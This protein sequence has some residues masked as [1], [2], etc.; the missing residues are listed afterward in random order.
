MAR[1]TFVKKAQQRFE[2]VAVIDPTTGKQKV[3]PVMGRDGKQ[4]SDKNGR[5]TFLRVTEVDRSK[6]LPNRKCEKCGKEIEVGTP[7]KWIKPKSGPY[8]GHMKVRCGGCP[9]WHV[10]D[11]SS[12]LSARIAQISYEAGEAFDNST[13]TTADDVT[14]ILSTAA[15]SI[16]E[17]AEEKRESANNIEEG[18]GHETEK[19]SELNEIADN[20]ESWADDVENND[21]EDA[22]E[23]N[24][25]VDHEFEATE[26]EDGDQDACQVDGCEKSEPEHEELYEEVLDTWRDDVRSSLDILE[27][28]P[29]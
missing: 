29:V 8:G 27:E 21:V 24:D 28:S 6:P 18:F 16:R 5:L 17:L 10:W 23:E 13:I 4:K 2:M 20:L 3:T 14:E 22:P 25:Y 26:D 9:T 1:I 12:S 19:S 11:Y 15:E 7:Y